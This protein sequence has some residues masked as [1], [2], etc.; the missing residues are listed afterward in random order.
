[1]RQ[2][3]WGLVE[4]LNRAHSD[5]PALKN[6]VFALGYEAFK[7][8]TETRYLAYRKARLEGKPPPAAHMAVCN[9]ARYLPPPPFWSPPYMYTF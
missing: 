2:Y 7:V 3:P 6:L 5:V 4:V 9:S 1:M 8:D